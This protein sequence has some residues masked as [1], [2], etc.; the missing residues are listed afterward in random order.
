MTKRDKLLK[1]CL[2]D[3]LMKLN[4]RSDF[5]NTCVIQILENISGN[6]TYRRCCEYDSC[7]KCIEAYLNEK[8]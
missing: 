8:E 7:E 3:L 4:K 2:F 6:A 1:M 5:K